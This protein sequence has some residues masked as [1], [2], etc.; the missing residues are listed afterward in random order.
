MRLFT[1]SLMVLLFS[2]LA[3]CHG[4]TTP[5]GNAGDTVLPRSQSELLVD[6]VQVSIQDIPAVWLLFLDE[7]GQP[8]KTSTGTVRR[9][10]ELL[11]SLHQL[12]SFARS[13]DAEGEVLVD[14]TRCRY[15]VLNIIS[16]DLPSAGGCA[17]L[18]L[19]DLVLERK[20]G[21]AEDYTRHLTLG[22][23]LFIAG[24][25]QGAP[26]SSVS[27]ELATEVRI[28]PVTVIDRQPFDADGKLRE[29]VIAKQ[30]NGLIETEVGGASGAPVFVVDTLAND[31]T[32]VLICIG[33][34]GG[35]TEGLDEKGRVVGHYPLI[36]RPNSAKLR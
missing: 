11:I 27:G 28:L 36:Y 3:G 34:L 31:S 18:Q 35:V 17:Q 4:T 25:P 29:F 19:Q 22:T 6:G 1:T 15:R 30:V 12:P 23:R 32:K 13:V 2:V 14:G 26:G 9:S 16:S 24:V 20:S 33:I 21:L 7:Q 8:V 10:N 5:R